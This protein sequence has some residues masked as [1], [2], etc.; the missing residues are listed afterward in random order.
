MALGRRGVIASAVALSI[1]LVGAAQADPAA[2]AT[3]NAEAATQEVET[4][5]AAMLATMKQGQQLGYQGRLAKLQ[6][7]ILASY[8]FPFIAEKSVGRVWND[9]DADERAELVDA[10]ERPRRAPPT[11]RAWRISAVRSSRRSAPRRRARTRSSCTRRSSTRRAQPIPLDYRLRDTEAGPRI[12]DVFYDG[13][14]SELA[15]RRSEYSSLLK[16]GGIQALLEALSKKIDEQA[17]AKPPA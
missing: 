13:T 4:L 10:I 8:D 5:H 2:R 14:V 3:P 17:T 12:V 1:W 6:P 7:A 16:R 15:M 11:R 9:L